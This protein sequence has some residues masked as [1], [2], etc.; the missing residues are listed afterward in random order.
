MIRN[1]FLDILNSWP[2]QRV[3]GG[4]KRHGAA[5]DVDSSALAQILE[6]ISS[7]CA[8]YVPFIL[9]KQEVHPIFCGKKIL[10]K[11]IT[12]QILKD[13]LQLSR[14]CAHDGSG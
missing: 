7:R 10:F 3:Q 13:V 6:I 1:C 11:N 12:R 9:G 4:K 8:L 2:I 5:E 14:F